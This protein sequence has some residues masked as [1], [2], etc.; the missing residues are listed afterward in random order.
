M[1]AAIKKIT[2]GSGVYNNE[3]NPFTTNW[4]QI[5]WGDNYSRLLSI[6]RK[7]DPRGLLTCWKCVGWEESQAA[8]SSFC[9]LV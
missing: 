6:K 7:Y 1:T 9:V 5:W 8:S 4:R 2:P 3:A